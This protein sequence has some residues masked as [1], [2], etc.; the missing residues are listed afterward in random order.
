LKFIVSSHYWATP[1]EQT[2]DFMPPVVCSDL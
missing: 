1:S 2:E